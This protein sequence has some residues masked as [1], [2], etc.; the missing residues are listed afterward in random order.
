[1]LRKL[2]SALRSLACPG[3][4]R[5]RH[6]LLCGLTLGAWTSRGLAQTA[7]ESSDLFVRLRYSV[8]ASTAGCWDE[9]QFRRAVARA[10]GYDPF[11]DDA[12]LALE[13]LIGGDAARVD[14]RV[15]WKTAYGGSM[16]ERRFIAKDGDCAR[17]LTEM[18]FAVGLQIDLL[19]PKRGAGAASRDSSNGA[20]ERRPSSAGLPALP[21]RS[22]AR[23]APPPAM[24]SE[25]DRAA[26]RRA[27]SR[28]QLWL[29][30]GPAL[31]WGAAPSLTGQGRVFLGVRRGALSLELAAAGTLPVLERSGD[32][33]GFRQYLLGGGAALCG[34]AAAF[35]ACA[36]GQASGLKVRGLDVDQP[37]SPDAFVAQAGARLG[38]GL[39]MSQRWSLQSH[40]DALGLLTPR[41]VDLQR[42]TVWEMPLFSLAAGIDVAARFQ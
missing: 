33:S 24:S 5:I 22:D 6:A 12:G 7:A 35:S 27:G 39:Q 34:H 30:A 18:S 36:L 40:L 1:M 29:G 32:G 25:R 2:A 14:G 26:S 17:L 13:V 11:R 21:S 9:P 28:W 8:D 37:R 41:R 10:V 3:V 31:A 19:R 23:A 20:D 16:G 15:D 42:V 4:P 38:A